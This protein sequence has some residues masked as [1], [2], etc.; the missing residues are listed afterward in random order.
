V[1]PQVRILACDEHHPQPRRQLGEELL[2]QPQR[3]RRVK[4]VQVVD[5]QHDGRG[6]RSEV[7][8]QPVDDRLAAKAGVAA[9]RSTAP[10]APASAR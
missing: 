8:A 9:R 3:V 2:E 10:S 7:G 4:L 1:Q 5:D 6:E